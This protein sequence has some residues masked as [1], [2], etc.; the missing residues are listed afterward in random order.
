MRSSFLAALFNKLVLMS[1]PFLFCKIVIVGEM[2]SEE[3]LGAGLG[4]GQG[5][6]RLRYPIFFRNLLVKVR[7]NIIG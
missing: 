1:E 6:S 3:V 4:H 5:L 7:K 2:W